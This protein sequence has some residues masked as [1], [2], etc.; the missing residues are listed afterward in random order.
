MSDDDRDGMFSFCAKFKKKFC[1]ACLRADKKVRAKTRNQNFITDPKFHGYASTAMKATNNKEF[2]VQFD[3]HIAFKQI[4]S[5]SFSFKMWWLWVEVVKE[6]DCDM[7]VV[8]K[9]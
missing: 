6:K 7:V 4:D 8:M 1:N 3:F 9:S 2:N 5:E